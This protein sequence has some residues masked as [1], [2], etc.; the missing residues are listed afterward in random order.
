ME[1]IEDIYDFILKTKFEYWMTDVLKDIKII[2]FAILCQD[3]TYKTNIYNKMTDKYAFD[4]D[5]IGYA[6]AIEIISSNYSL[7]NLSEESII[8][9]S[10]S[11]LR[12]WVIRCSGYMCVR[13]ISEENI[14]EGLELYMKRF[15]LSDEVSDIYTLQ[16]RL[17]DIDEDILSCLRASI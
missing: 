4:L 12:R 8:R 6:K 1:K 7:K 10:L 3:V 16:G 14:T 11:M 13:R 15:V 9:N 2:E 5:R 17:D